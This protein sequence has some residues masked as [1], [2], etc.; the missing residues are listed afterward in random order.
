LARKF[1][2]TAKTAVSQLSESGMWG[3]KFPWSQANSILSPQTVQGRN[4]VPEAPA[5]TLPVLS[6]CKPTIAKASPESIPLLDMKIKAN[7]F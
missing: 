3:W 2:K 1:Q 6:T 7:E 4:S 5:P